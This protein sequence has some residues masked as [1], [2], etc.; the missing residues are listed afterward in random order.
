MKLG[1]QSRENK[2]LTQRNPTEMMYLTLTLPLLP[3]GFLARQGPTKSAYA[4]KFTRTG[5]Q[6]DSRRGRANNSSTYGR[7]P[8]LSI[9]QTQPYHEPVE[10]NP[11]EGSIILHRQYLSRGR[12]GPPNRRRP[13]VVVP[14]QWQGFL[15]GNLFILHIFIIS[16]VYCQ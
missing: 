15:A 12:K 8:V 1:R 14:G 5:R 9:A 16:N 3:A 7:S 6:A 2:R 13:V 11:L 4:T 10:Q